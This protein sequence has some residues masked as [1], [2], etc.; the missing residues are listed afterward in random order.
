MTIL[1]FLLVVLTESLL[2]IQI[3]RLDVVTAARTFAI[4]SDCLMQ[5]Y[6]ISNC[7]AGIKFGRIRFEAGHFGGFSR[8]Q[9]FCRRVQSQCVPCAETNCRGIK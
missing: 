5:Y 3:G 7:G 6:A 1:G 8:K 9:F 2:L 4:L